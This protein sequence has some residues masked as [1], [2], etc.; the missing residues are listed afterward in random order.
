MADVPGLQAVVGA[1]Q[2]HVAD[3]VGVEE[4][5]E[6]VQGQVQLGAGAQEEGAQGLDGVLAGLGGHPREVGAHHVRLERKWN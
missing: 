5:A 4:G 3:G 2:A 6:R 1:A